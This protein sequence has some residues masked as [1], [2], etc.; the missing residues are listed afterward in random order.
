MH[1]HVVTL[2]LVLLAA[3]LGAGWY[4]EHARYAGTV[5][6]MSRAFPAPDAQPA[7]IAPSMRPM[8]ADTSQPA[9]NL[10]PVPPSPAEQ[11]R[12]TALDVARY[13]AAF[14]AD[15]F[16][17]AWAQQ[18]EHAMG[19]AAASSMLAPFAPPV[20]AAAECRRTMCRMVFAF[21]TRAQAEDWVSFFPPVVGAALPRM[22]SLQ[23]ARPDGSIELRMYGYREAR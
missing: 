2:L 18:T 14:A 6:A 1:R 11:R 3:G 13:D 22:Q 4:R 15:G 7:L 17:S 8:V 23:V 21:A 9:P 12:R 10:R 19:E 20:D 5:P 16:D